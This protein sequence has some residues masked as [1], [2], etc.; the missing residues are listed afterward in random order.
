MIEVATSTSPWPAAKSTV[1]LARGSRAVYHVDA[2]NRT[3]ALAKLRANADAVRAMG[4]I[5][6]YL[7]GSTARDESGAAS[8][9][10]LFLDYDPGARF[11]AFEAFA[12]SATTSGN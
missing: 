11:N 2:M 3:D 4:A 10:D 8:D 12:K 7:Y 1:A 6:L 9:V 5:S